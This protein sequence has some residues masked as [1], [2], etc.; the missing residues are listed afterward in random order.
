MLILDY[1]ISKLTSSKV[2]G[3]LQIKQLHK[4]KKRCALWPTSNCN[5]AYP[6]VENAKL[7]KKEE[8]CLCYTCDK[9]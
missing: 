9:A 6:R 4:Y 1:V 2:K 5:C 8:G 3:Y 7:E